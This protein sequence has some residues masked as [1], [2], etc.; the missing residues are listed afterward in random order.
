MKTSN[1]FLLGIVAC[2][3]WAGLALV[4]AASGPSTNYVY[5]LPLMTSASPPPMSFAYWIL[6]IAI[7]TAVVASVIARQSPK[8]PKLAYL[9][10]YPI[11]GFLLG[12]VANKMGDQHFHWFITGIAGALGVFVA[13][14]YHYVVTDYVQKSHV[15]TKSH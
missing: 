8:L 7:A 1:K 4:Q 2:L 15:T 12:L 6:G 13:E 10:S 5:L 3:A 11:I 9:I 14:V